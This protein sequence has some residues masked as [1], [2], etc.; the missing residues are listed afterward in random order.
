MNYQRIYQEIDIAIKNMSNM[1]METREGQENLMYSVGEAF[2][3]N[4]N[5]IVEAQVGIG[6]SLGYLIPG[7][8]ISRITNKPLIVASS[9]IQLTEQLSNDIKR[10][11]IFLTLTLNV[12]LVKALQIILALKKYMLT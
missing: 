2:E 9:T 4:E 8:I 3:K 7:V 10:L 1:G 5:V 12:L 11:K 6:K